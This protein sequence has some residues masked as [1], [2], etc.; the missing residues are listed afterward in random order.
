MFT[1]GLRR[2]PSKKRPSPGPCSDRRSPAM[3]SG[4]C[5]TEPSALDGWCTQMVTLQI[6]AP[7]CARDRRVCGVL[8]PFG[9]SNA[10]ETAD[11]SKQ[12]TQENASF[13]AICQVS[14]KRTVDLDCVDRQGLKVLP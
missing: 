4:R 3:L 10:A 1:P 11:P 2:D 6:A 9:H 7:F 12:I 13:V 14:H 8:H 5:L